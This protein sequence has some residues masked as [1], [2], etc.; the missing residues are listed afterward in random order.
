MTGYRVIAPGHPEWVS[1]LHEM[2]S[3][4]A[5]RRL[6]VTGSPIDPEVRRIAIVGTRR[7][8]AAGVEAAQQFGA[9]LA[10]AG[11]CI[12]SGMAIGIDAAAHRAALDAGGK[13]IA[14][15]GCGLDVPYPVRNAGLHRRLRA[16][17]TIVSEYEE[18]TQPLPHH[19]PARNRIIVGLSEAAVVIEG[20]VRSGALI[21]AR[22]ALDA[23]R[24]VFAVPGSFRNPMAVGPN[25]LIRASQATPAT[26]VEHILDVLSSDLQWDRSGPDIVVHLDEDE[27]A[28]LSLLDD[29]PITPS[30]VARELQQGN[31]E[32]S[33][34]LSSLEIRGFAVKKSSGYEL[35]SSGAAAR[36]AR[37]IA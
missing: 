11:W 15:V 26:Q 12:V 2:D 19:F 30:Y 17:G 6:F 35:T 33:L 31:R 21:T 7:P 24:E 36:G 25:G 3:I 14:V 16:A 20:G 5:P 22:L 32:V 37:S 28:V 23:N 18:G 8:T 10:S 1:G 29:S 9:A 34:A 4:G 13:A 27:A